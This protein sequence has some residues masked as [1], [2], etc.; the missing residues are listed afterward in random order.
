MAMDPTTNPADYWRG[1]YGWDRE[2]GLYEIGW[3]NTEPLV[4]VRVAVSL[5]LRP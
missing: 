5:S 1:K 3:Q 4:G 2:A